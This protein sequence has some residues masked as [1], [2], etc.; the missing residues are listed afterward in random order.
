MALSCLLAIGSFRR[1]SDL[2][3]VSVDE[4]QLLSVELS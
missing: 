1:Y 2:S 4:R 3:H